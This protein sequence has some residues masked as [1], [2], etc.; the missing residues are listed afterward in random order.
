MNIRIQTYEA[1]NGEKQTTAFEALEK[2]F[3]DLADLCDVVGEVFGS[4]REKFGQTA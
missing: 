2:G 1:E 4:E 3:S